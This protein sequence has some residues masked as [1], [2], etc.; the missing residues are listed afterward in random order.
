VIDD[1]SHFDAPTRASFQAI[2]P[3][4]RPGGVYVIEDWNWVHYPAE[5][6]DGTG[7]ADHFRTGRP[8]TDLVADLVKV[9]GS[10]ASVVSELRVTGAGV[11]VVRGKAALE[12][13]FDLSDHI[14]EH[15]L[16]TDSDPPAAGISST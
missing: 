7:F 12:A 4:M 6:F 13:P 15:D 16:W 8:P 11:E 14:V 10:D 1:A 5:F 3:L 9:V 2:F